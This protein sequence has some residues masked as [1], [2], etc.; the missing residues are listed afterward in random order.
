M[1]T[2]NLWR[3]LGILKKLLVFL[4]FSEMSKK[5]SRFWR[6]F[7]GRVVN[8]AFDVGIGWFWE[9]FIAPW[10]NHFRRSVEDFPL[11]IS[12]KRS[13][14]LIISWQWAEDF[15]SFVK[16]IE[17]GLPELLST[18]FQE[19]FERF[20]F[21]KKVLIFFFFFGHL[22]K[23]FWLFVIFFNGVV[24]NVFY[25]S[26]GTLRWK[27]FLKIIQVLNSFVD[28]DRK[29]FAHPASFFRPGWRNCI[30]CLYRYISRRIK[31]KF[32]LSFLDNEH[33]LF[34]CKNCILHVPI[35]I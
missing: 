6:K 31:K 26:I 5:L 32:S 19:Q 15:R 8:T 10:A 9:V 1:S 3:K 16:K 7:F 28:F 18:C 33:N 17:A 23:I 13:K 22:A 27:K 35:T 25:V 12:E 30:L 2:R 11:A 20:V 21:L 29:K 34:C 14:F 24:D 4:F